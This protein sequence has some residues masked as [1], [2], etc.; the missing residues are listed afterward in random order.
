MVVLAAQ[1]CQVMV[2]RIQVQVVFQ[3][4]QVEQVHQ[5]AD[6]LRRRLRLRLQ[7]QALVLRQLQS[8]L[9]K[10]RSLIR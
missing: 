8:L 9:A 7:T 4:A 1:A 6:R 10:L 3:L 5:A 2:L